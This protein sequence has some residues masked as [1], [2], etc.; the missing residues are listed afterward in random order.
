MV[1]ESSFKIIQALSMKAGERKVSAM[2]TAGSL[3]RPELYISENGKTTFL[4]GRE[5]LSTQ[6]SPFSRATSR[7]PREIFGVSCS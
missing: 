1:E 7:K 5:L 4:M 6:T 2:A 3:S